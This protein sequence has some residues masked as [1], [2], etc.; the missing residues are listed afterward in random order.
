MS[1]HA[2]VGAGGE[3]TERDIAG[4]ARCRRMQPARAVGRVEIDCNAPA[5]P[6]FCAAA[7]PAVVATAAASSL[8]KTARYAGGR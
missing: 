7:A 8:A 2:V 4:A 3:C 1:A 5:V 6:T